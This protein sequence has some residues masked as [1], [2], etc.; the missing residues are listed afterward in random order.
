VTA[1]YLVEGSRGAYD[2]QETWVVEAHNTEASA[3]AR[4]AELNLLAAEFARAREVPGMLNDHR[5][6]EAWTSA[7]RSRAGD[8][9][10]TS[11]SDYCCYPVAL[12]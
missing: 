11:D 3:A 9:L 6:P 7:Y 10:F 2:E 12:K 4:V 8:D 5:V 1:V